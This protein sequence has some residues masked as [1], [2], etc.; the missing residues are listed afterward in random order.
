C[1]VPLTWTAFAGAAA[2]GLGF[3]VVFPSGMSAAGEVPG[4]G[5]R[6]IA[7]VSTIGYGGFLF[8]APM[9]GGLAHAIPLLDALLVVAAFAL[10]IVALALAARE[11]SPQTT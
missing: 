9:I 8:G 1:L 3:S 5:E 2:W 4:R 11:R 6:A 10:L 7:T